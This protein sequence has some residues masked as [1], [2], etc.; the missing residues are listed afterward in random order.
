[1]DPVKAAGTWSML[2]EWLKHS[3]ELLALPNELA[4]CEIVAPDTPHHKEVAKIVAFKF[5]QGVRTF[6]SVILL[7]QAGDATNSFILMRSLFESLVDVAYLIDN[8]K[9]V[10]RYLEESADLELKLRDAEVTYG[11][12][13]AAQISGKRP[14][15]EELRARFS[16]LAAENSSCK[17]WRKLSLKAR[18]EKTGYPDI[19]AWYEIVYPTASAYVHGASS[20]LLDYLRGAKDSPSEFRVDYHRV[21]SELE[22]SVGLSAMIFLRLVA[23][24]DALFGVGLRPRVEELAEHQRRLHNESY[25]RLVAKYATT[26]AHGAA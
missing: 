13:A 15:V 2:D 12:P 18:A 24:L 10:W 17:S 23:F 7:V 8:P 6:R 26:A 14:S 21:D 25:S 16:T 22:P 9:D 19:V 3:Q 4:G 11:P 5:A 20:I 1:M